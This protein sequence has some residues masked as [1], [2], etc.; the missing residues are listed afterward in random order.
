MMLS[1]LKSWRGKFLAPGNLEVEQRAAAWQPQEQPK[2][3]PKDQA[4]ERDDNSW[5]T[6]TVSVLWAMD[7]CS[8]ENRPLLVIVWR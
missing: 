1:G 8:L 6:G 5:R 7:E 3:A 2:F 4:C